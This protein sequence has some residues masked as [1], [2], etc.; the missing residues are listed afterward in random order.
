MT[1]SPSK[2][3]A[4]L[5]NRKQAK[6]EKE[7]QRILGWSVAPTRTVLQIARDIEPFP[8][9]VRDTLPVPSWKMSIVDRFYATVLVTALAS[10]V[11]LTEF[12]LAQRRLLR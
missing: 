7:V 6:V 2:I 12:N 11:L 4:N 10:S 1:M 8:A 3:L 9:K 5:R